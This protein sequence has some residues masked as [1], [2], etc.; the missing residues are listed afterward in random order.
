M[1]NIIK[2]MQTILYGS[3]ALH[4]FMNNGDIDTDK[5][6]DLCHVFDY[7]R[8]NDLFFGN[9]DTKNSYLELDIKRRKQRLS[10]HD[11]I[12]TFIHHV[13]SKKDDLVFDHIFCPD[14]L[15][16]P[17][18]LLCND[19]I[20]FFTVEGVICTAPNMYEYRWPQYYNL[21]QI[22]VHAHCKKLYFS[23]PE[24]I[25]ELICGH[26][27]FQYTARFERFLSRTVKFI[28]KQ[29]ILHPEV[30]KIICKLCPIVPSPEEVQSK[31]HHY[32]KKLIS[33]SYFLINILQDFFPYH[34]CVIIVRRM[35]NDFFYY[36]S[37][38]SIEEPKDY[39]W[40]LGELYF[41]S[42]LIRNRIKYIREYLRII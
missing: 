13:Q 30:I 26:E 22:R 23:R 20:F 27:C 41:Q 21:K 4:G 18:Q 24:N 36:N 32:L 15:T 28:Q 40:T 14:E 42:N 2:I 17:K 6:I 1:T 7:H 8:Q 10:S 9:I 11:I 34:L 16:T 37:Q 5:D 39:S 19:T 31:H 33:K 12:C 38:L 3:N 29:Y 25:I 35:C